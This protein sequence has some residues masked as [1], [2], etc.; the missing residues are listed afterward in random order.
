VRIISI[1]RIAYLLKVRLTTILPWGHLAGIAVCSVVAAAPAYWLSRTSTLPRPVVLVA[2]GALYWIVYAAIAFVAFKWERRE[3]RQVR[4]T[5]S[6]PE[7][8]IP[9]PRLNPEI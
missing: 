7:S 3:P 6:S 1:A 4:V 5:S 9:N 2:A 8:L